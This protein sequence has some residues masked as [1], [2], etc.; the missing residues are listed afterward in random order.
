M[1]LNGSAQVLLHLTKTTNNPKK[2][3]QV[4]KKRMLDVKQLQHF[5]LCNTMCYGTLNFNAN[6]FV[7]MDLIG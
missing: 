4:H 2:S 3:I 6:C 1:I 5:I 7:S